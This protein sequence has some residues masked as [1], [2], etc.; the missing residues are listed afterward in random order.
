MSPACKN[1]AN[2]ARRM[3]RT[4]LEATGNSVL[5]SSPNSLKSFMKLEPVTQTLILK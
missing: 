3:F 1:S 4:A 2:V 5:T